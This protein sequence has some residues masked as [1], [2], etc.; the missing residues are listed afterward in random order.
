[1]TRTP[2]IGT[3]LLFGLAVTITVTPPLSLSVPP[4][5]TDV[6]R[7][8]LLRED[9]PEKSLKHSQIADYVWDEEVVNLS[10][11]RPS[12]DR[13]R[14]TR[15]ALVMMSA[16]WLAA[17]TYSARY[18]PRAQRSRSSWA[19]RKMCLVFLKATGS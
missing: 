5:D 19:A 12:I 11:M 6:T 2:Y 10:R 16:N 8:P 14:L 15:R 3:D 13:C 9:L 18:R 4:T 7:H 1:M 17:S